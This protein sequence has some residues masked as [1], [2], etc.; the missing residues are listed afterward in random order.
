MTEYSDGTSLTDYSL[1]WCKIKYFLD[2]MTQIL[3]FSII[4]FAAFDQF[5]STSYWYTLRRMSTFKLAQ[6]LIFIATCL[7]II[8]STS[9]LI[10]CGIFPP[11]GCTV[12]NKIVLYYS[13]F[14]YYPIIVGILPISIS[15]LFSLIA[16]R[17][18]RHIIRRQ[19][20]IMRRR[21]DHQLTAMV[22]MR[23][24]AFVILFLP[25]VIYRTFTLVKLASPNYDIPFLFDVLMQKSVVLLRDV[26]YAVRSISSCLF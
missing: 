26:D 9:A 21:L 1:V 23:V 12:N 16:F 14:V 24:I 20:P 2:Q 15:S 22:F 4:C 8:H 19:V 10:F 13:L 11:I 3:P 5:L 6:R 7:A 25:Y 18:V 17:N